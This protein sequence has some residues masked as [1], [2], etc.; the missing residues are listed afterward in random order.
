[1][2]S[3]SAPFRIAVIGGGPAGMATVAHCIDRELT[4]ILWIDKEH[5]NGGRMAHFSEIHRYA[6][7]PPCL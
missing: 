4:P 1:M 3:P 5:F 7:H 2:P 6:K